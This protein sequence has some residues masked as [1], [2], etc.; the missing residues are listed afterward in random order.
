MIRLKI[1][2]R[3]QQTVVNNSKAQGGRIGYNM[4]GIDTP[5]QGIGALNPRIGYQVG[6]S[7]IPGIPGIGKAMR[8]VEFPSNELGAIDTTVQEDVSTT[9][10]N[11][12]QETVMTLVNSHIVGSTQEAIEQAH[13]LNEYE[14]NSPGV[15]KLL[16]P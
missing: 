10:G 15:T 11:Q 13:V 9:G 14:I 1:L 2:T 3:L 6:S 8:D 12:I 4:G 5:F 16:C 7:D